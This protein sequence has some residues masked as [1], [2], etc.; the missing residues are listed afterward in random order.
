MKE[1]YRVSVCAEKL[2]VLKKGKEAENIFTIIRQ[3][4][5]SP[6]SSSLSDAGIIDSGEK[7]PSLLF[8]NGGFQGLGICVNWNT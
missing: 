8:N 1:N 5:S 3:N 6:L 4:K 2:P 7:N